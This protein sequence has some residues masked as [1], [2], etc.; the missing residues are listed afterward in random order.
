MRAAVL[1]VLL[2][3]VSA[4][5]APAGADARGPLG[6]AA[7]GVRLVAGKA[8]EAFSWVP[9]GASILLGAFSKDVHDL[10]T[11]IGPGGEAGEAQ[12]TAPRESPGA[13]AGPPGTPEVPRPLIR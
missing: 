3:L 12:A 1:G 5:F 6:S 8:V 11:T 2:V 13:P 7:Y 4:T 9:K 10:A